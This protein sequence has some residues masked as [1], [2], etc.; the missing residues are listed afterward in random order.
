MNTTFTYQGR[1]FDLSTYVDPHPGMAGRDRVY[2]TDSCSRCGGS[3]IYR[4]VNAM[5]LCEGSCF[6]CWGTGKVERSNAVQ[7]LRRDAKLDALF[8]EYGDQLAAEQA[9]VAAERAA[10]E[11]AEELARAWDEAHREQARRA[12]LNRETVGEIGERLRNLDAVIN[13]SASFERDK[14]QGYGTELVKIV[15]ATLTGGQVVKMQGTSTNLYGLNRGD[16]VK[17]T[18]TVKGYGEYKGQ[19]QT[20]LQR[21]KIEVV[22]KAPEK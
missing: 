8:R 6:G 12:S 3:G 19:V 22:E 5:G 21:P 1:R 17:L 7:T 15:V 10:A 11:Q 16:K 4:W 13:V 9:A 2:W 18:G 14:F 20:I